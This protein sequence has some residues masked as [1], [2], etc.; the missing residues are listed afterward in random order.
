MSIQTAFGV[1]D[2]L[3]EPADAERA[4]RWHQPGLLVGEPVGGVAE[5]LALLGDVG[6]EGLALVSERRCLS[7]HVDLQSSGGGGHTAA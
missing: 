1:G 3:D 4:R 7:S 6:E 2:V 5:A